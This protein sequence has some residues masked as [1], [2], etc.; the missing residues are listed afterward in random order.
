MVCIID[1][2]VSS[3]GLVSF[4]C[5][6]FRDSEFVGQLIWG[7]SESQNMKGVPDCFRLNWQA[8]IYVGF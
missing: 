5:H 2:W 6:R 1:R 4:S 7:Q 3:Y 8:S